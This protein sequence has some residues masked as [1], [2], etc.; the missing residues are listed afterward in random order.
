M[1][2]VA[3]SSADTTAS[4]GAV[5]AV[6]ADP[7]LRPEWHPR[8]EWASQDGPLRPGTPGR[9]KP[10]GA[11]PVD[12]VVGEVDEGRRLVHTG[13]H[14]HGP[15]LAQGHYLYEVVELPGGGAR[16]TH[17]VALSGILARPLGAVLGRMLGRPASPAA[18]LA[19]ARLAEAA[20]TGPGAGCRSERPP[21]AGE[22]GRD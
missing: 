10:A 21:T 14:G 4:T 3:E 2:T 7:A 12:V 15:R 16:I 9:W 13:T 17:R 22:T 20:E 11:R 18:V 8:L 19:V 5:W 6:W 1:R